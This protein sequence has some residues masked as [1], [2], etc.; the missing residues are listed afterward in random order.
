MRA[1]GKMEDERLDIAG[2]KEVVRVGLLWN[3]GHL[4][5]QEGEERG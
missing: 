2:T 5:I 3:C 4:F 1:S